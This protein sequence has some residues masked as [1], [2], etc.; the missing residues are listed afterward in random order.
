MKKLLLLAIVACSFSTIATAQSAEMT[1][2]QKAQLK[3]QKEESLNSALKE[4]QLTDE[5]CVQI[6]E[7]LKNADEIAKTIKSDATMS[8]EQKSE[9][10]EQITNAKNEKLKVI[11]GDEKFKQWKI[12]RKKPKDAYDA[13]E[14]A[15]KH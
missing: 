12:I 5:Q 15:K 14:A 2:E 1:K 9:K 7:V 4:L 13:A 6:K 8:E 3:T 10:K 11:M